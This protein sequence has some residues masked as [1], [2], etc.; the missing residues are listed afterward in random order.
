MIKHV[1]H[2]TIVIYF[3]CDS[4]IGKMSYN[5]MCIYFFIETLT[6]L[7]IFNTLNVNR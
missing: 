1:T 5:N 4:H 7:Y 3:Q 6:E 2:S